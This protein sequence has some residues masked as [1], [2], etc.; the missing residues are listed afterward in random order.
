MYREIRQSHLKN[1]CGV[2][3]RIPPP[4]NTHKGPARGGSTQPYKRGP[5]PRGVW[6]LKK[7]KK[8]M[9]AK[10]LHGQRYPMPLIEA[11]AISSSKDVI[12]SPKGVIPSSEVVTP[13]SG[14]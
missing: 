3:R 4:P 14:A 2:G 5:G 1:L 11:G 10:A 9:V 8:K 12:L 13:S 6:A 7:N